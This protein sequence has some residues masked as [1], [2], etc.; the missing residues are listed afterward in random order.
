M[1]EAGGACRRVAR[2]LATDGQQGIL[3]TTL[4]ADTT[5]MYEEEKENYPASQAG[6]QCHHDGQAAGVPGE[7]RDHESGVTLTYFFPGAGS[8]PLRLTD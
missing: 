7:P 5:A 6:G 1:Q 2:L 8:F 4:T 3:S